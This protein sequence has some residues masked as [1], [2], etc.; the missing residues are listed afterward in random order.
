MD[1]PSY[2]TLKSGQQINMLVGNQVAIG[3]PVP[4]QRTTESVAVQP[5]PMYQYAGSDVGE[6]A[7]EIPM[8]GTF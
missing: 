8:G 4:P 1:T 6:Q 7:A 2:R 3:V 5:R